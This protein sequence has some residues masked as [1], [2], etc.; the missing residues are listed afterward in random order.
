MEGEWL[1]MAGKRQGLS[2]HGRRREE[3]EGAPPLSEL[4]LIAS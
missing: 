3:E 4:L 2:S 1:L